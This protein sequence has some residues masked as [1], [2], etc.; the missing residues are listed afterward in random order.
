MHSR[1]RPTKPV[2]PTCRLGQGDP[3]RLAALPGQLFRPV[4]PTLTGRGC[5]PLEMHGNRNWHESRMTTAVETRT[6]RRSTPEPRD[7]ELRC[8]A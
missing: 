4:R 1:T 6:D 7:L 2:L 8:V 5:K 3:A